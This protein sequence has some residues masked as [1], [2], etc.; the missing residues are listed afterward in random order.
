MSH[1]PRVN[2]AKMPFNGNWCSETEAVW[3]FV[4]LGTW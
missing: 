3:G 1:I 4:E 2:I